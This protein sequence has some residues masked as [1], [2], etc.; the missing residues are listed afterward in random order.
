M[1]AAAASRWVQN[2]D[3]RLHLREWA[4]SEPAIVVVPGITSP[5]ATWAFVIEA[6]DL[7][8]RVIVP[9][10]RG[11][12]L[13]SSPASGYAIADY[14][15]DIVCLIESLG[16]TSPILLGHSMGARVVAGVDAAHPRLCS[17]VIAVDPPLSGPGRAPYPMAR[18]FY[19]GQMAK[20]LA[21]ATAKDLAAAEPGWEAARL[22]ERVQWL[23]S[24]AT[25]AIDGTLASFH[26]EDFLPIWA[27]V[28]ARACC[29]VGETSKV[30][31]PDG[32]N[33]IASANPNAPIL[34]VPEAGHMVPF[35]NLGGFVQSVRDVLAA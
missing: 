9:D 13:S 26:D 32:R 10:M 20:V 8:N 17:G 19:L 22:Q 7:P 15:S 31:S 29:I 4:G 30:V 1:T 28:S 2:G 5:A 16:I 27:K 34:S 24:V 21:G 25:Q 33:E 12:G 35:D 14:V 6:L 11:R 23:P 3:I 18:D